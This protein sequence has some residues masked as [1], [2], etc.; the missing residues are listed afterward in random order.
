MG[1]ANRAL[2]ESLKARLKTLREERE[3]FTQYLDN[4][5]RA[6][7]DARREGKKYARARHSCCGRRD[8]C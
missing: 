6:N 8:E 7:F 2:I 3:L 1:G 5:I 4:T